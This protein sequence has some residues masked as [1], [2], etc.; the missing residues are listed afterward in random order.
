MAILPSSVATLGFQLA[1]K[2]VNL[3]KKDPISL[4]YPYSKLTDK[5]DYLKIEVI[6]YKAPGLDTSGGANSFA[7]RT[8]LIS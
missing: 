2:G 1:S 7:L 6:E 8:S 5:D 3:A 4:R